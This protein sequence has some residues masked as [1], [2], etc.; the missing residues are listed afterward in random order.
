MERKYILLNEKPIMCRVK[1]EYFTDG[2]VEILPVSF[3]L[4]ED[5]EVKGII[6]KTGLGLGA[7]VIIEQHNIKGYF[8]K[9]ECITPLKK[10]LD[11]K[12]SFSVFQ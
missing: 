12:T 10:E 2:K 3:V 11:H 6:H 5:G 1:E 8:I 7:A 4:F 9:I